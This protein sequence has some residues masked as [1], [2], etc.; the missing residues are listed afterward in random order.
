MTGMKHDIEEQFEAAVLFAMEILDEFDET[1]AAPP[2]AAVLDTIEDEYNAAIQ[3]HRW[4]DPKLV[5][6]AFQSLLDVAQ[7][8]ATNRP[9]EYDPE[10]VVGAPNLDAPLFRFVRKAGRPVN[11]RG[12]ID[13]AF[14]VGAVVGR[15][16]LTTSRNAEPAPHKPLNG[17]ISAIDAVVE[18]QMRRHRIPNSYSGIRD[19]VE[20]SEQAKDAFEEGRLLG[21]DEARPVAK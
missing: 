21:S 6:W 20:R 12:A 16:G 4:M 7:F 11:K 3:E 17:K 13:I 14:A 2:I 18:A 8:P 19:C 1:R 15:F 5:M 10:T 9:E